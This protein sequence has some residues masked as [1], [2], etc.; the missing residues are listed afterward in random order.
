MGVGAEKGFSGFST[1]TTKVRARWLMVGLKRPEVCA[2]RVKFL[3]SLG[4]QAVVIKRSVT[5]C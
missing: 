1:R 4:L 5:C 3:V 2:E